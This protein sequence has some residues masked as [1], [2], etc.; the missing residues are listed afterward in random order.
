M[1]LTDTEKTEYQRR[2]FFVRYGTFSEKECL[3]FREAAQRV[4]KKLLEEISGATAGSITK[5]YRLDGN[6]FVDFN[7]VTVQLEHS[8]ARDCLRVVE[9]VNDVEPV[10]DQLLDDP[11]LREPM[12]GLVPSQHL[13]LWTAKLNFKHPRVGS[14]FGWHQDAPYWIHDCDHVQQLPNVMVL[15]DD[16]NADN[17]CFR[18][19]DGSHRAGCLPGCEDGRQLQGF[20]TH[21]DCVDETAQVLI[22]APAGSAIFFDP[23]IVHGSG[24]NE[25]DNPRRAII[26]TYQPAGFAALKS[27][28]VREI[29]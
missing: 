27:G 16:A 29:R 28:Q 13:A 1:V 17:G 10:F 14:G 12:M 6:C 26:I 11:R 18:V 3:V 24:P 7:H 2:G 15:F 20:Y 21:P 25:S 5:E 19:I 9:P 22:D 8:A 23:H 4:E